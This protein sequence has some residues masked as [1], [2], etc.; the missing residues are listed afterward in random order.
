MAST[1]APPT[2][3]PGDPKTPEAA[4]ALE[5]FDKAMQLP[6][7]LAALVPV[8]LSLA[9]TRDTI[10]A[11]VFVISWVVFVFD[12]VVRVRLTHQYVRTGRG[13]FDLAI[14]VLTAPWFLLPGMQE[15][16]FVVAV[17]LARLAR[18]VFAS[19]S[20]KHLLQR[21]GRAAGFAVVMV[22]VCAYI[23]YQAEHDINPEYATFWDSMWWGIVTLTTVGYG[24]VVPETGVGRW[25]GVMLMIT[26]VGI[27][28]A[29][30]GSLANFL[31]LDADPP[32]QPDGEAAPTSAERIAALRSKIAALDAELEELAGA[33]EGET[34]SRA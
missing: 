9:N 12:F 30:A 25:A 4:A 33:V 29:L 8:L 20:A 7:V 19:R 2:L 23:A 26:G 1:H 21:L 10:A 24:D 31:K 22:T 15:S 27:I 18:L 17:R 32:P 5:R 3:K 6:I 13:K 34:S 14:V 11:V 28:G 16:R